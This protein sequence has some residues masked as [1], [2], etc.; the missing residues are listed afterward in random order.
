MSVHALTIE[1]AGILES[2]ISD[3]SIRQSEKLCQIKGLQ[4]CEI[5]VKALWDTGANRSC[6]SVNTARRLGLL[7]VDTS[8]TVG[9]GGVFSSFVHLVDII[10]PNMISVRNVR[11]TEFIDEGDFDVIIGMDI[12]TCGDFAVSNYGGKTLVSFRVPPQ[13]PPLDF[14]ASATPK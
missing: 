10:L 11:G 5:V 6:V 8:D 9:V 13:N 12:I 2:I 7:K 14:R 1:S 3:V 4:N